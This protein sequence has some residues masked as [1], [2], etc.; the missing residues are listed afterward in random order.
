MR[1]FFKTVVSILLLSGLIDPI[2]HAA[3]ASADISKIITVSDFRGKEINLAHPARRIVCLIESALSGIY[4]LGAEKQVVGISANVYENSVFPC[5]A[6]MD[7]RVHHHE[8][9]APG[10]WDFVNIERIISLKPDLVIIWSNQSESIASIEEKHIPVYGVFI[11]RFDDIYKEIDDL[12]KLTGKVNRAGDLVQIAH[13]KITAVQETIRKSHPASP[14]RVYYMWSQGDLE[15]SG[16]NSTVNELITLAGG[17]NVAGHL[18]QEHLVINL[19]NILIWNPEII[20]MWANDRK[21]PQS[22]MANT[23]WQSVSAVKQHRVY[24]FPDVFSCDLWTLKYI[25]AVTLVANWCYPE[26]FSKCDSSECKWDL[27][28]ELYGLKLDPAAVK[29]IKANE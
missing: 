5:Y 12:G 27:F 2:A 16:A 24:E 4:M 20:V 29:M 14:V 18:H 10:N 7:S 1:G 25:H 6:A 8:L 26:L 19:E 9:P 3:P 21:N 15:T 11:K 28:K 17:M 23:L 22:I 13:E